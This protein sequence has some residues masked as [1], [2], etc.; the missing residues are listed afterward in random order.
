M[1]IGFDAK[2]AFLNYTGLGNYSRFVINALSQYFPENDY[3]LFTPKENGISETQD[4]YDRPN[5][6]I[7]TPSKLISTFHLSSYWRTYRLAGIAE[8]NHVDVFHGLSNELPLDNSNKSLKKIVTIHDLLF[9]RY[10]HLY[11]KLDVELYRRKFKFAC[12]NADR[13]IAVSQQTAL[14]ITRFFNIDPSQIDVVYQGCLPQF[15]RE[16][17][18][19]RLLRVKDKYR[20]PADFILNVG[21][22]EP[23]KNTLQIIKAMIINKKIDIPLVIVGRATKYKNEIINLA[24]KEGLDKQIIF[25]HN[26]PTDDLPK[27]YQMA[28]VFVYPSIFEGFGIPIVEALH[29]KVPV[30]SSKGSCFI[31]AGGNSSIYVDPTDPEELAESIYK[32]LNNSALTAKMIKDGYEHVQ[33]FEENIIAEKLMKVYQKA[34][35]R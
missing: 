30:I 19:I 20:L 3:L 17:D 6:E 11:K 8:R 2:R 23:R 26:V 22:I 13:I 10:P 15:K 34:I 12:Q 5:I 35:N 4:F 33:N 7:K 1:K 9:I 27:I 21:T 18:P 28:K 16:Y 14:D 24:R 25:L 31:E 32:V 29:S